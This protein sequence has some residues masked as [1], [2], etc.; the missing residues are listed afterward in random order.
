M[1]SSPVV[2]ASTVLATEEAICFS[3]ELD[4]MVM[5]KGLDALTGLMMEVEVV[6][7]CC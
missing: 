4:L 2:R 3:V 6:C 5:E 7:C 1:T